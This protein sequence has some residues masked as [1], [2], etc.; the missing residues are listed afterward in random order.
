MRRWE[1]KNRT[2]VTISRTVSTYSKKLLSRSALA[3]IRLAISP[4]D[5]ARLNWL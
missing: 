3:R 4:G 2:P 5:G 1:K